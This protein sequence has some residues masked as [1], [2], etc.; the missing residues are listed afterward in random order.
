MA[1]TVTTISK[2][3]LGVL[4][5]AA[6]IPDGHG[7][8]LINEIARELLKAVEPLPEVTFEEALIATLPM[9]L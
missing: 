5:Q 8:L 1:K 9:E 6:A 3:A 4:R 2:E 7:V